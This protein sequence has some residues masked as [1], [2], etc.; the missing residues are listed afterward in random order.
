MAL[1]EHLHAAVLLRRVD[2]RDPDRQHL[3][4]PTVQRQV[5]EWLCLVKGQGQVKVKSKSNQVSDEWLYKVKS[6]EVK[7][8]LV[9]CKSSRLS[10]L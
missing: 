1:L 3:P 10:T 7:F 8:V 2:Q 6:S 9:G 4:G 5:S